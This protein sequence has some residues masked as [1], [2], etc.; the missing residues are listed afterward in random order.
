MG[1]RYHTQGIGQPPRIN[2]GICQH[3]C[4]LSQGLTVIMNIH[5]QLMDVHILIPQSLSQL[6]SD[7]T[8]QP[9]MNFTGQ[10]SDHCCTDWPA[11]PAGPGTDSSQHGQPPAF[12]L[13][14]TTLDTGSRSGGVLSHQLHANHRRKDSI[15]CGP[16][17][18]LT[19]SEML[20]YSFF[21]GKSD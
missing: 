12:L 21:S 15:C 11:E 9:P 10:N 19:I 4:D 18:S 5:E 17:V 20:Q 13:N 2:H 3:L 8:E 6:G 16:G 1:N 14:T 7:Y